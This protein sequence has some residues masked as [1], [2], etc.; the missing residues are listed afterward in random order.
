MR[1]QNGYVVQVK[2]SYGDD[3]D[4]IDL[5]F[6]EENYPLGLSVFENLEIAEQHCVKFMRNYDVELRILK[7]FKGTR[8]HV[9]SY[10]AKQVQ[11]RSVLPNWLK[12]GF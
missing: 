8:L 11:Y 10:T 9:N 2:S 4:W 3:P 7:Q 6:I 1:E 5:T 12:E